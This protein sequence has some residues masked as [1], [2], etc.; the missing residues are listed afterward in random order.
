[1]SKTWRWF[2]VVA[3]LLMTSGLAGA[4]WLQWSRRHRAQSRG[5]AFRVRRRGVDGRV[6]P[7]TQLI[8]RN[9]QLT[10]LAAVA[11]SPR[12]RSDA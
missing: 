10:G 6:Q 12:S 3:A 4:A 5:R 9:V 7:N 2:V 8:S 11:R 1:M